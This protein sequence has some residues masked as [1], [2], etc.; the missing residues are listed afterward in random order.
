[1]V[2]PVGHP[3]WQIGQKVAL[4]E[5]D[6]PWSIDRVSVDSARYVRL[7]RVGP[8]G[9]MNRLRVRSSV[10]HAYVGAVARL[11]PDRDIQSEFGIRVRALR[12]ESDLSQ[13]ELAP[14]IGIHW[15]LLGRIETGRR[16]TSLREIYDL[17][18]ALD[19]T[20]SALLP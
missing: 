15:G 1:M 18:I 5:P 4:R 20:P 3:D 9:H 16:P 17:A 13:S 19:V 8:D 10:L 11:Q 7:S 14:L 12:V 2:N 6:A